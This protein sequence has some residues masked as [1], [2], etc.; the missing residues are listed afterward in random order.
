MARGMLA[1]FGS[2]VQ[3]KEHDVVPPDEILF[4]VVA[5][6]RPLARVLV[7]AYVSKMPVPS[8]QLSEM[9]R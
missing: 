5:A 3:L 6:V 7:A 9:F 1:L 2:S 4:Y 8:G